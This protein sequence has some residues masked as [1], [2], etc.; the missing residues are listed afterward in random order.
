MK[1]RK[2][3]D[4]IVKNNETKKRGACRVGSACRCLEPLGTGVDPFPVETELLTVG[5]AAAAVPVNG[6]VPKDGSGNGRTSLSVL[7][8]VPS[9]RA[10]L[11][12]TPTTSVQSPC[13][14]S[15]ERRSAEVSGGQRLRRRCKAWKL[16]LLAS[17][18]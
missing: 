12:R 14:P 4:E 13:G 9:N 10:H 6:H 17:Q 8:A 2:E 16:T 15:S 18:G 3:K 1:E 11:W 7:C 5:G